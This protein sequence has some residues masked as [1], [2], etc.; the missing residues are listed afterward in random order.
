MPGIQLY[1]KCDIK[2]LTTVN[3]T[4]NSDIDILEKLKSENERLKHDV[5]NIIF[6]NLKNFF[7]Y[8]FSTVT[9]IHTHTYL[10]FKKL[11][12]FFYISYLIGV[13]NLIIL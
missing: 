9:I 2:I 13:G 11:K 4:I 3:K 10:F 1:Y 8:K 12:L 7:L 5:Q 6:I